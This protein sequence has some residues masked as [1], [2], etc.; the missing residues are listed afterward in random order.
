MTRLTKTSKRRNRK[1]SIGAVITLLATTLVS[2]QT[3]SGGGESTAASTSTEST[4]G[5]TIATTTT[6]VATAETLKVGIMV[7]LS[8]PGASSGTK[9]ERYI[10]MGLDDIN[11]GGGIEVGDKLYQFEAVTV[12]DKSSAE[13]G[14]EAANRLA[15][16][17]K[18]RFILGPIAV[19]TA[20]AQAV[21][22]PNGVMIFAFNAVPKS[23][24][25]DFPLTFQSLPA[26]PTRIQ[27][28][29]DWLAEDYPDVKRIAVIAPD[30]ANGRSAAE[31]V[32]AAAADRGIDVATTEF[33]LTDTKDFGPLVSR[34]LR[35]NPDAIDITLGGGRSPLLLGI[36]QA[37]SD[38][39]YTGLVYGLSGEAATLQQAATY[40]KTFDL[41]VY[42]LSDTTADVVS[43]GERDVLSR[44]AE[45]YGAENTDPTVLSAYLIPLLL[46]QAMEQ[47]STVEDTQLV[48]EALRTGEFDGLSGKTHLVGEQTFGLAVVPEQT[49]Y[50]TKVHAGEVTT[51]RA[52]LATLP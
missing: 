35:E 17:E 5:A 27:V 50:L 1:V 52:A 39:G 6:T 34:V 45:L 4:T 40:I 38:Q 42:G 33:Y 47:A 7:S 44:H 19:Q 3:T 13:G 14:R 24:G 51:F 49:G 46:A 16:A 15:L 21:T 2:C 26:L 37:L 30:E 10:R 11:A 31:R 23:L 43:E 29:Y 12:D 22:E 28:V 8:G 25:P 20:G 32:T 18:V 41:V 9:I 48:A 36:T